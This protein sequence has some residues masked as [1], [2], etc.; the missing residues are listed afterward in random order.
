MSNDNKKEQSVESH[1][2][3]MLYH[4]F[5]DRTNEDEYFLVVIAPE[6]PLQP[7]VQIDLKTFI[8]NLNL[9]YKEQK[10]DI[11]KIEISDTSCVVYLDP[12]SEFIDMIEKRI[13]GATVYGALHILAMKICYFLSEHGHEKYYN[14]DLGY[15]TKRKNPTIFLQD[16]VVMD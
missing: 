11:L 5:H 8:S 7:T 14:I 1:P 15:K 16:L 13:T 12:K 3:D 9:G 4:S 2:L 10:I 6:K